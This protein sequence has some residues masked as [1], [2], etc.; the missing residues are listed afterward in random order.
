MALNAWEESHTSLLHISKKIQWGEEPTINL[1]PGR[2]DVE[3][4]RLHQYR[5]AIQIARED[6]IAT[7]DNAENARILPPTEDRQKYIRIYMSKRPEDACKSPS[8]K[9]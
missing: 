6:T 9:S 7:T 8:A 1:T 5:D 2:K 3:S 4:K